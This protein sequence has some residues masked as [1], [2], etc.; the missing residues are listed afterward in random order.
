M[1]IRVYFRKLREV[2]ESIEGECVVVVSEAT[3]DGGK[4][5][6]VAEVERRTAAKLIV[7]GRAR[8]AT[9]EEAREYRAQAEQAR[10]AAEQSALAGRVQLAVLS[11]QEL[12]AL[13]SSLRPQKG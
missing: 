6:V 2:E 1:D 13:R 10:A 5:G 12:R 8:L 11:D 7:D 4:A 9:E 3:S